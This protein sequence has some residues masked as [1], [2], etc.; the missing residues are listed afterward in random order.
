VYQ[1]GYRDDSGIQF[2]SKAGVAVIHVPIL[3]D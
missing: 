3:E 1:N 2:L